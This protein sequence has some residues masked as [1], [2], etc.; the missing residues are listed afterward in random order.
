MEMGT[1]MALVMTFFANPDAG[2]LII[3]LF[4]IACLIGFVGW[5]RDKGE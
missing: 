5:V 1:G 2:Y 3:A 4:V